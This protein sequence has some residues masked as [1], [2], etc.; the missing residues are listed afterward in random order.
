MQSKKQ[1]G[2]TIVE[3]IITTAIAAIVALAAAPAIVAQIEDAGMEGTAAYMAMVKTGM[4]RYNLRNHDVLANGTA[5]ALVTPAVV[6][7][8]APTIAELV[9][10]KYISGSSLTSTTPQRQQILT[11]I[12]TPNCPGVSCTIVGLAYTNA[13]LYK[14]GTTNVRYDL[15]LTYLA[16]PALSGSG[17][18][19][20]LGMTGALLEG[21][22]GIS[23]SNPLGA[24]PGI[25][26]VSTQMDE[27]LFASFVRRFDTRDPDLQGG[28]T[29]S[30]LL[31]SGNT[32]QVNGNVNIAGNSTVTGVLQAGSVAINNS[33]SLGSACSVNNALV[34]GVLAGM[35]VLLK[36]QSGFYVATGITVVAVG[37][38]CFT[39][40]KIAQTVSGANLVCS[41]GLYRM[42]SDLFGKQGL[43]NVGVYSNGDIV[44]SHTCGA[45]M[46][47]LLLPLGVLSACVIGGGVCAN[48]TGAFRGSIEPGNIVSITG[49]DGTSAG[50]AQMTVASLCSTT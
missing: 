15:L 18:V 31:P 20:K 21:M 27:A 25:L 6:N 23:Q 13:P 19:T 44:P 2:F 7:A 30:G 14:V 50:S 5:Q 41:G 3:L 16:S 32:L 11:Q 10:D 39:E 9:R 43:M 12:T 34:Q 47:P 33:G 46:T 8:Y 42:V 35:P 26:A 45:T 40:A 37:S 38:A 1:R 22:S 28:A 4:E 49:S 29:I 48:N 36:C 17:L 24:V